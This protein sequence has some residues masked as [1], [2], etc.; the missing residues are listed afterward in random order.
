MLE[1]C[2]IADINKEHNLKIHLTPE[3]QLSY[4]KLD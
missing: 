1:L 4:K 3:S 2:V